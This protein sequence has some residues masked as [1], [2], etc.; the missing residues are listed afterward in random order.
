MARG[1]PEKEE[2]EAR[3]SRLQLAIEHDDIDLLHNLIVEDKELLD[4]LSRDPFR[5]TPL[6]IAAAEG[7]F[8]V[9]MEMF[10]LR[11][12]F[13]HKLNPEGYSPMHL[14]LQHKQYSIVRA[15][16]T[17]DP[18]LIRVR[19]RCG[20][21]PLHYIA[22]EAKDNEVELLAEFLCTCKSSIEDLTCR[23]ETAVHIAVKNHNLEAFDV[24]LGWLSRVHLKKILSWEDKDGNTVLHVAASGEPQH[25]MI[26][27]LARQR[28]VNVNVK[29]FDKKTALEIY[30]VHPRKKQDV[31]DELQQKGHRERFGERLYKVFFIPNL[32]LSLSKFFTVRLTF[33]ERSAIYFYIEDKSTR[34]VILV[35]STLMATATYQAALS[36]PGG[37]WQDSSSNPLTNSTEIAHEKPH[38]AGKMIL[39]GSH[40]YLFTSLNSMTFLISMC[41]IL[42]AS[43][44]LFPGTSLVCCSMFVLAATYFSSL[45]TG[46]QNY[47]DVGKKLIVGVF[48]VAMGLVFGLSVWIW[49]RR[50]RV[51][52]KINASMRRIGDF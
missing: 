39:S 44:P 36:P 4:R 48:T 13:A 38:Q 30:Q 18:E 31:V 23:C 28:D 34:E 27:S 47:N 9:A 42:A 12:E 21:T 35:V 11:P 46:F 50:A 22:G 19:G 26:K 25:E 45:T 1:L 2:R 8:E 43:V 29:N 24:L 7:K 51:Q 32:D 20:I 41:I 52:R 16:M 49:L 17:L 14:A 15:L 10:I 6:H 33:L 37:Y 40:L 3:E 5:N